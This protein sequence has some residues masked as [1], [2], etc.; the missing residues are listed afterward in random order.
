MIADKGRLL[1]I[2]LV[3]PVFGSDLHG[4]LGVIGGGA[5]VLGLCLVVSIPGMGLMVILIPSGM[6]SILRVH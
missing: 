2:L 3:N 4:S 5:H 1:S 6:F